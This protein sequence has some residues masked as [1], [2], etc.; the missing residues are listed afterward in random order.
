MRQAKGIKMETLNSKPFT[1]AAFTARCQFLRERRN[2]S[3]REAALALNWSAS[4]YRDVE[5][6]QKR[7]L[8]ADATQIAKL[9]EVPLEWLALGETD[10]LSE[11]M[12]AELKEHLEVRAHYFL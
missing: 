4:S 8:L 6:N 9:F 12:K 1:I 2:W 3:Q 10:R 7:C 11:E 5:Q